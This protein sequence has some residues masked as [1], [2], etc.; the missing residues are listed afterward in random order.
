MRHIGFP[1][2]RMRQSARTLTLEL[3]QQA[4][5]L[6]TSSVASWYNAGHRNGRT[7]PHQTNSL[8]EKEICSQNHIHSSYTQLSD[9][10]SRQQIGRTLFTPFPPIHLLTSL[11]LRS[12]QINVHRSYVHLYAT[13]WP[14]YTSSSLQQSL[15]RPRQQ[16]LFYSKH[17]RLSSKHP[18]SLSHLF[19]VPPSSQP[20]VVAC[21][22]QNWSRWLAFKLSCKGY[23][24]HGWW[25]D[26]SSLINKILRFRSRFLSQNNGSQHK[27]ENR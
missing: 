9:N 4:W 1:E 22:S 6:P 17:S 26:S 8:N 11:Y 16:P 24:P 3:L 27:R 25:N 10:P 20:V 13:H 14:R 2:T 15:S 21:I 18:F 23:G 19:L 7:S 12:R 5:I